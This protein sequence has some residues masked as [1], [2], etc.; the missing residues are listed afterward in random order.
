ML[1][2]DN[3]S[4]ADRKKRF[5]IMPPCYGKRYDLVHKFPTDNN[6]AELWRQIVNVP[7]L[8]NHSIEEIRKRMYICSKH[9]A[10]RDYKHMESRSLNKTAIPTLYLKIGDEEPPSNHSENL[11][12]VDNMDDTPMRKRRCSNSMSEFV[13]EIDDTPIKKCKYQNSDST[14]ADV[15][16][17][18]QTIE[19]DKDLIYDLDKDFLVDN[20]DII[21]VNNV[22]ANE[23]IEQLEEERVENINVQS[24]DIMGGESD[25]PLPISIETHTNGFKISNKIFLRIFF[26]SVK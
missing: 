24:F 16:P 14:L 17:K 1:K 25:E 21:V 13:D 18:F 19:I 10:K 7:D 15:E 23:L 3:E 22:H 2:D 20:D 4:A 12:D 5:C 6:R 9:F 26:L 8:Y 11:I